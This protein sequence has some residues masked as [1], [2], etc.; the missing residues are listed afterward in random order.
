MTS[1]LQVPKD[2]QNLPIICLIVFS[3]EAMESCCSSACWGERWALELEGTSCRPQVRGKVELVSFFPPHQLMRSWVQSSQLLPPGSG[4][5]QQCLQDHCS[6][7]CVAY[8]WIIRVSC[9]LSLQARQHGK[10]IEIMMG[11]VMQWYHYLYQAVTDALLKADHGSFLRAATGLMNTSF[12]ASLPAWS[13]I[14]WNPWES[15]CSENHIHSYC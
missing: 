11:C 13:R 2:S 10:A 4:V 9:S 6:D 7:I 15:W 14:V 8:F 5:W 3:L 1:T 12:Y